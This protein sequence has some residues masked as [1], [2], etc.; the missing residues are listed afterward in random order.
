MDAIVARRELSMFYRIVTVLTLLLSLLVPASVMAQPLPTT[1][2]EQLLTQLSAADPVERRIA[3]YQLGLLPF[4]AVQ[5]TNALIMATHD[6][7]RDVRAVAAAALG[8]RV[9]A[10]A[11]VLDALT[12]LLGDAQ[13]TVRYAAARALGQLGPVALATTP[14]LLTT[15]GQDTNGDVRYAAAV[16]VSQIGINDT[17]AAI[18]VLVPALADPHWYARQAAATALATIPRAAGHEFATL[19]NNIDSDWTIRNQMVDLAPAIGVQ[20]TADF[21]P[22]L[23]VAGTQPSARMF[24]SIALLR[25]LPPSAALP[26]YQ[27]WAATGSRVIQIEAAGALGYLGESSIPHLLPL[28]RSNGFGVSPAAL[29]ALRAIGPSAIE[30]SVNDVM[31]QW[32]DGS[33]ADQL[34]ALALLR[35]FGHDAVA[36]APLIRARLPNTTDE[37]LVTAL[38]ATLAAIAPAQPDTLDTLLTIAQSDLRSQE[39]RRAAIVALGH[40]GPDATSV[41]SAL[42]ALLTVE[43]QS[44]LPALLEAVVE[45]GDG[46]PTV[47]NAL[48]TIGSDDAWSDGA[49]S[50]ALTSLADMGMAVAG[51]EPL[52]EAQLATTQTLEIYTTTIVALGAI[53][54]Q[55]A[56]AIPLLR[57]LATSGEP[58]IAD[59]AANALGAIGAPATATLITLLRPEWSPAVQ[60][61]ATQALVAQGSGVLPSLNY[62]MNVEGVAVRLQIVDILG[63]IGPPAIQSILIALQDSEPSVHAAAAA[64]LQRLFAAYAEDNGTGELHVISGFSVPEAIPLLIAALQS[65]DRAR[66]QQSAAALGFIG[67]AAAVAAPQ[68]G[69]ALTSD[70]HAVR[71]TALLALIYMG[72]AA[73]AATPY[74]AQALAAPAT[75]ERCVTGKAFR[76]V[77]SR[78]PHEAASERMIALSR[79]HGEETERQILLLEAL[80]LLGTPAPE[81]VPSLLDRLRDA[82]LRRYAA[83]ALRTVGAGAGSALATIFMRPVMT[84]TTSATALPIELQE[85]LTGMDNDLRR[86]AIYALPLIEPLPSEVRTVVNALANDPG[87]DPA[88]RDMASTVLADQDDADRARRQG[89]ARQP[90]FLAPLADPISCPHWSTMNVQQPLRFDRYWELCLYALPNA[91]APTID[92]IYQ[93]I[94]EWLG[95]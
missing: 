50:A 14:A 84:S 57:E 28:L 92:Q 72:P 73:A 30:Q 12:A 46:A 9:I 31:E 6:E 65:P 68:L 4:P 2:W 71:C 29:A 11:P 27:T 76:L 21:V 1:P 37:P 16:A 32:V 95:G 8:K 34:Q 62:A 81:A 87:E 53:G 7:D 67:P 39:E 85:A 51:V 25:S 55:A 38:V 66:Q 3:A 69:M 78:R 17:G 42:L 44:L 36:A 49:R 86:S 5:I 93:A 48:M 59:A 15:I 77:L 24:G 26:L 64:L 63:Q 20:W 75:A 58:Q 83:E 33:T 13:P 41:L 54:S 56:H 89:T 61:R 45:I 74:V 79:L 18:D 19:L 90:P 91:E 82:T 88:L 47:V 52:L 43:N 22:M 94:L 60:A 10:G 23:A 35:A 70:D 40:Y 80:T